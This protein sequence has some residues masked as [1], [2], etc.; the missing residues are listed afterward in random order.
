MN[1]IR[2]TKWAMWLTTACAVHCFLSP[3]IMITFP[4][5]G[6]QFF[7]NPLI[8]F[9]FMALGFSF[10]IYAVFNG[11]R[12]NHRNINLPFFLIAGILLI[13]VA[14][15]I[16]ITSL[17]ITVGLIGSLLVIGSLIK[18]QLLLKSCSQKTK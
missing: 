6:V 17:E 9:S 3:I 13:V 10:S 18:N 15:F 8:E 1:L 7:E 2:Q 16:S 4:L 14:H 5:I 11:Y 12:K